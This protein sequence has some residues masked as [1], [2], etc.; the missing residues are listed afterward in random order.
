[1]AF[2]EHG[3]AGASVRDLER[4]TGLSV[5]SLYNAFGDK[6]GLYRAAFEH[7]FRMVID[8]RLCAAATLE[9]LETAFLALAEPPMADG[10][11]CLIIN[12]AMEFGGD[13]ASPAADLIARGVDTIEESL[14]RVLESELGSDAG[15][16]ALRLG[17]IYRGLLVASRSPRP[18]DP[19]MP[20]VREEFD[21]LRQ[22]RS[23]KT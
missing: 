2:R 16:A 1:M 6:A 8:P 4:A 3:F 19:F 17:L 5:G 10:F 9:D 12:G 15:A 18:I 13:A 7:Y 22:L 20:A 21:R 23:S 14:A 11:G